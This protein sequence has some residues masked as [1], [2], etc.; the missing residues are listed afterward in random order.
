[1]FQDYLPGFTEESLPF[2]VVLHVGTLISLLIY[3]RRD[4]RKMAGAFFKLGDRGLRGERRLALLLI[5]GCIPAGIIGIGFK[6]EIA[7]LFNDTTILPVMFLVTALILVIGE[8][9]GGRSSRG[10]VG[11]SDEGEEGGGGIYREIGIKDA[12]IIGTIQA[13]AIIPGISRSG[14]TI[15]VGLLLG[16]KRETAAR[17]SFLLS[18][19]A[20]SGAFLLSIS[21]LSG[22]D[23]S[24]IIGGL[25]AVVV[26]LLAIRLTIGA[27]ITKKLWVFSLY[28]LILGMTLMILGIFT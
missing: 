23:L 9:M 22:F 26:G 4:I 19:P 11:V 7:K 1:M 18:I 28:L 3:F 13:V 27:V 25:V 24:Y 6:E 14:S 12:L 10:E 20:V 17:F 2:D 8:R 5:V 15:A 21:D 16:L